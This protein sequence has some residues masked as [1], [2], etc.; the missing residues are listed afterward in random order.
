MDSRLE[1]RRYTLAFRHAVRTAH[2]PWAAREGLLVRLEGADGAVGLGEAAPIPHFGGETS[3]EDAAFCQSLGGRVDERAL[4]AVPA[5]LP[6]LRAAFACAL[7]RTPWAPAQ[8]SLAVAA[9]LPPGTA[10]LGACAP[11]ADAG[12]R[13]F[14]W[15]VG[16]GD[17]KD[18]RSILDDLIGALPSG[19]RLR[20][21]ANGAWTL[22]E[23]ERWLE[24]AAERPAVEFIEQPLAWDSRGVEDNLRGLAADHPVP[25]ALDESIARD[26]DI[27]RWIGLDWPGFYVVKPSLLGDPRAT[28]GRLFVASTRVVFSSAL[29]TAVGAREALRMAFAW[30]G[31]PRA[32]GFGVW[33]LF[34]D[35]RFDGPAAA[36][37]IRIEDV[38]RMDPQLTWNALN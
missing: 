19:S 24:R 32:L 36:P 17:P 15:K 1:F 10:S 3:E 33:P 37:M 5:G 7:R 34:S 28:L 31:T 35:G 20:L 13:S 6:A 11:L 23:S 9:L 2:G 27:E 22:A 30:P 26:G 29:E 16:T 18:E 25:I 14:K 38:E 21:D 4:S 12:F 8:R